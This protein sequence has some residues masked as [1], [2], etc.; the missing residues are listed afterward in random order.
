MCVVV[1]PIPTRLYRRSA[2]Y[3]CN[4]RTATHS[5]LQPPSA[6]QPPLKKKTTYHQQPAPPR[7]QRKQQRQHRVTFST[8]SSLHIVTNLTFHYKHILW[9]TSE[10]IQRK[11]RKIE[12]FT[13]LLK[14]K[15]IDK[16][17]FDE[18][19]L[20]GLEKHL[21]DDYDSSSNGSGSS[22]QE[23]FAA[24]L[25]EQRRQ[26][27]FDIQDV[28]ALAMISRGMSQRARDRARIIGVLQSL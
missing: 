14:S 2:S 16:A 21:H 7:Q 24:V 9:L 13:Y 3:P 18:V 28:E 22:R 11:K 27:N 5:I 19:L 1:S 20:M 17:E 23:L 15:R 6:V 8:S 26:G 4:K 25:N 10:E 12:L